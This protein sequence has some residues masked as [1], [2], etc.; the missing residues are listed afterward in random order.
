MRP[1][2]RCA[3]YCDPRLRVR[4]QT[5]SATHDRPRG[6]GTELETGAGGSRDASLDEGRG[7]ESVHRDRTQG[8]VGSQLGKR[9]GQRQYGEPVASLVDRLGQH[10]AKK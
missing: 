2:V 7:P 5:E 10:Y 9:A 1:C 3:P 6:P 8:V 4:G